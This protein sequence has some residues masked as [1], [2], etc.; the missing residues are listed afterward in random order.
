[1]LEGASVKMAGSYVLLACVPN[2]TYPEATWSTR[3]VNKVRSRGSQDRCLSN[4][5]RYFQSPRSI[6][7]TM[8][9]FKHRSIAR[10][11]S[12]QCVPERSA[13]CFP[14][15]SVVT[16]SFDEPLVDAGWTARINEDPADALRSQTRSEKGEEHRSG[17]HRLSAIISML[18]SE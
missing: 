1:M 2:Q 16:R 10:A 9:M 5:D 13:F 4:I 18:M 12:P 7:E 8:T 17:G 6:C 15:V 11:A 14:K 3:R